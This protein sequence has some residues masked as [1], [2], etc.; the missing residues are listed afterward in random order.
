VS[1][2]PKEEPEK[3]KRWREEQKSRLK[4][5]GTFLYAFGFVHLI[6]KIL[7]L[8]F[9]KSRWRRGNEKRWNE[10]CSP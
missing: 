10:R 6:Y 2:P 4:T 8:I 5:K 9:I 1:V 3:I 7:I